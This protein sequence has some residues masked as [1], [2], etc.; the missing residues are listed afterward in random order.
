MDSKKLEIVKVTQQAGVT[1]D[2]R[3]L[4]NVL[5]TFTVDG[6]GPFQETFDKASFDP[7]AARAKLME[8]AQKLQSLSS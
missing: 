7:V 1:A 8:F 3:A 5:V 4:N 6:H 2:G